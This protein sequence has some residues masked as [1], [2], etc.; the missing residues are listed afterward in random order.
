MLCAKNQCYL[1]RDCITILVVQRFTLENCVTQLFGS[2]LK[3]FP[4][5]FAQ[6]RTFA[7]KPVK[8]R[9]AYSQETGA[10]EKEKERDKFGAVGAAKKTFRKEEQKAILE[11]D[12]IDYE[13]IEDI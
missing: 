1:V 10:K 11:D 13:E 12:L 7:K 2:N 5:E 8:S 3:I 9:S 6:L 4:K